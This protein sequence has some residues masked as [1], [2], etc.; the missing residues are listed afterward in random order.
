M[1]DAI[2]AP[3]FWLRIGLL[4]EERSDAIC[5]WLEGLGTAEAGVFG[6]A[7]EVVAAVVEVLFM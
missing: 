7:G 5:E 1:A 6:G 3:G 2:E 4:T